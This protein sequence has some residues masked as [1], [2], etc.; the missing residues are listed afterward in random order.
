MRNVGYDTQAGSSAIAGVHM[1]QNI[2]GVCTGKAVCAV[3]G[4]EPRQWVVDLVGYTGQFNTAFTRCTATITYGSG[5]D[6]GGAVEIVE[7]DWPQ[8]GTTIAV[9][10]RDVRVEANYTVANL[11]LVGARPPA[12]LAAFITPAPASHRPMTATL[13]TP[14]ITQGASITTGFTVPERARSYRVLW[15]IGAS[16]GNAGPI[17][18]AQLSRNATPAALAVDT[19]TAGDTASPLGP[20]ALGYSDFSL[21][22]H[23]AAWIPLHPRAA[24]LNVQTFALAV[25]EYSIQWLLE[26]G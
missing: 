18:A 2:A 22:A 4:A 13:T 25:A 1:P 21:T 24:V 20:T 9:H 7:V 10:G 12:N 15:V 3:N 5:G 17:L 16:G 8:A 26:L 14:T 23:R 11:D 19:L 6:G